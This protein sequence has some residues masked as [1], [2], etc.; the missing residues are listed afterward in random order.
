MLLAKLAGA[1]AAPMQQ[2]A[3]LLQ[4]LP[5][6]FAY[7]LKALIEQQGGAP[8]AAADRRARA[9]ARPPT[10]TRTR[11]RPR[12]PSPRHLP[13]SAPAAEADRPD[14]DRDGRDRRPGRDTDDR[15][16]LNMATLTKDEI[17]DAIAG[18]TRARAERAAEG[19]RG[20][21]RR[22]RRR[23]RRRGRCRRRRRRRRAGRGRGGEGRVRR[24]PHRRRRQ[25]D[26][27]HQGRPQ[28]VTSLGLKEAKDLVDA[29]PKPV[30]EKVTK[31]DAEKAKAALE[32]AGATVELK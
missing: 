18:M 31:E 12:P 28:V 26:R 13:T 2:F 11:R 19:L 29:A 10:T 17:L 4:A 14:R 22:H 8:G 9:R 3:G 24:R 32:D 20:E 23:P 27:R 21:V 30:L 16:E 7:G 5:R 15:G 1:M 6:N 25:E